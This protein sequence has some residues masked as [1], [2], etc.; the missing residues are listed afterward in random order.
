MLGGDEGGS[1]QSSAKE[2]DWDLDE[3]FDEAEIL[4]LNPPKR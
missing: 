1:G 3:I 4:N 2:Q